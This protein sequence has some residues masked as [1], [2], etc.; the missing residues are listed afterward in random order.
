MLN[1]TPLILLFPLIGFVLLGLFGKRLPKALISLIGCGVV[2]LAFACAVADFVS[3]LGVSGAAQSS[4]ITIFNWVTS[5][6]L[7]ID[8]TLLSDPLSAVM[9]LIVTGVGFLIH[10][11]SIGYMA[12]DDGYWRFFSFL[13]LFIFAMT[14]LVAA[15]NFLFLLVGWAGVGLAS[16]LLIGYWYTRPSAVAAARKAFVVNVIGDFGLMLAIFLLFK[17]FGTLNYSEL[18][19]NSQRWCP[20]GLECSFDQAARLAGFAG[21]STM[22]AIA[23]L[24]L[25]AAVA[26]SAQLP[27]HV[28]LPDAMEGPTPVSALIHAATMVTAGVYLVA[29]A[30]S[31]FQAAPA[32]LAVVAVIGGASALFAATIACV[33]TDIKR[34]LA[35]ST[36]SQLAYMFMGEAAGG[37]SGGIF[38]LTTHAYFKALLFM[39]AGAVIH[40][41]AGEQDMRKMGGLRHKLPLTFWCFVVGG[42]ALAAVFPFDGFW[43]K[44]TILSSVLERATTSGDFGW[45]VLYAAGILTAALTGFYTFRLIFAVFLGEYRGPEIVPHGAEHAASAPASRPNGRNAARRDPLARVREV[46]AA[47]AVP[48]LILAALSI[49]GGFY[50][51]PIKPWLNE[52][53]VPSTGPAVELPNGSGLFWFSIVLS[54]AAALLGIGI[55]WARY[56][57]RQPRFAPSRNPFVI[58]L[59][60]RYYVDDLYDRAIVRP[61]VALGRW[62]R[63]DVEGVALDGGTRGVGGLIGGA[64][65]GLRALQTGYVRNYAL[66][67]FTGAVLIVLYYVIRP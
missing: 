11:Y 49:I 5:G 60:H 54:L 14:L 25:V 52:F 45:Y 16:F 18:L 46:G 21:Q 19:Y 26:K 13:N 47:M 24:L 35:Y 65:K 55:A 7:T 20:R 34:V 29:R 44:D 38:H 33:Q 22:L 17:T 58:L 42:L 48:M 3:M 41:L 63:R 43:S 51:T 10:V 28:W 32:S 61:I 59:E 36:M 27:L 30:H 2:L 64:S 50:D 37:F 1:L 8:F 40:A 66:A 39:A 9:L 31:I 56:G 12:D 62:L 57:S 4:N 23:L 53:L 67:I 15:G 6:G